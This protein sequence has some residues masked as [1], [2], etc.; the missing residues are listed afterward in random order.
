MTGCQGK[1]HSLGTGYQPEAGGKSQLPAIVWLL[2]GGAGAVNTRPLSFMCIVQRAGCTFAHLLW[3]SGFFTLFLTTAVRC[4]DASCVVW[5]MYLHKIEPHVSMSWCPWGALFSLPEDLRALPLLWCVVSISR[6]SLLSWEELSPPQYM[7]RES[8][9]VCS[10]CLP[11]GHS[12]L[13]WSWCLSAP[14][15]VHDGQRERC[16]YPCQIVTAVVCVWASAWPAGCCK[17]YSWLWALTGSSP[18]HC[19]H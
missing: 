4:W 12:L 9:P 10:I 13:G 7:H 8:A 16:H 2:F 6:R 15:S 5:G 17:I 14:H 1:L 11:H 18:S 3:F 19:Q